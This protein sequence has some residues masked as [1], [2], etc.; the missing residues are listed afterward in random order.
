MGYNQNMAYAICEGLYNYGGVAI[1]SIVDIQ[2][3]EQIKN[4]LRHMCADSDASK[5]PEIAYEWA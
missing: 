4:F 5:A 3:I 2:G 1:T